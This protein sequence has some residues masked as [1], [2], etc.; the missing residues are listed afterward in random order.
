MSPKKLSDRDKQEIIQL[1][2]QTEETTSTLATRYG[3]SS[4]TISRFLKTNLSE[5]EYENLIQQKRLARTSSRE[6]SPHAEIN[7]R[8]LELEIA[9][10]P[11]SKVSK[12]ANSKVIGLDSSNSGVSEKAPLRRRSSKRSSEGSIEASTT[13]T[14]EFSEITPSALVENIFN[15]IPS[16]P[17]EEQVST[18]QISPRP[19]SVI[20]TLPDIPSSKERGSLNLKASLPSP[21]VE[22]DVKVIPSKPEKPVKTKI[23]KKVQDT[24]QDDEAE[25]FLADDLDLSSDDSA[26]MDRANVI[27]L[28]EMLG[29]DLADLD[30]DDDDEEDLDDDDLDDDENWDLE[31]LQ[32]EKSF[33]APKQKGRDIQVLPVSKA[34]IPKICYLVVDRSAEL[35][36]L[37]MRDFADLGAIPDNEIQQR[38][39]PVFDN[40]R[41]AR[42]FSHRS[43]R[44]IKVPDGRMLQKTSSHLQAKGITRLLLDGQVY[45]LSLF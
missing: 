38:T 21:M 15:A 9:S 5:S 1:Y 28:R 10:S 29:E 30:D 36:T 37:P 27:T 20:K 2:K 8:Q 32:I 44:V 31:D 17:Q 35:I 16:V 43:Q 23:I 33:P 6:D 19:K 7:D 24:V 22:E 41:V 13:K 45:S 11:S 4:S 18:S 3:V 26:A 12:K 42:R 14:I 40:H 25:A 39:L 34:P